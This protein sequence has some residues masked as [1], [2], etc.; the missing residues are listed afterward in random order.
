[1]H[2]SGELLHAIVPVGAAAWET[3]EA[4]AVED[5]EKETEDT[6]WGKAC[7]EPAIDNKA[8]GTAKKKERIVWEIRSFELE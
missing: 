5:T 2:S 1:L 6:S 4:V 8:V 7:V 3:V